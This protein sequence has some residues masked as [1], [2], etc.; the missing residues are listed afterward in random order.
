MLANIGPPCI[1][2]CSRS[3]AYEAAQR[4]P[5]Q[6][7]QVVKAVKRRVATSTLSVAVWN[8]AETDRRR[9]GA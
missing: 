2:Y 8:V 3:Q 1:H 7:R 6:Y 4:K 9:K 5:T